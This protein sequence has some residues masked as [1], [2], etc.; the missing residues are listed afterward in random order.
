[1]PCV[2]SSGDTDADTLAPLLAM[3]EERDRMWVR[4]AGAGSFCMRRVSSL[5]DGGNRGITPISDIWK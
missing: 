4:I 5:R 2:E 1:M 3:V